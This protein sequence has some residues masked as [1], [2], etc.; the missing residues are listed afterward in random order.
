MQLC[1]GEY[2][3]PHWEFWA[4]YP[5]IAIWLVLDALILTLIWDAYGRELIIFSQG[6]WFSFISKDSKPNIINADPR[7]SVLFNGSAKYKTYKH[8]T[9]IDS[10]NHTSLNL[11][12]LLS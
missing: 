7:F 5:S 6:M 12:F 3:I 9:L 10:I 2:T 4:L 8:L 1:G 11:T